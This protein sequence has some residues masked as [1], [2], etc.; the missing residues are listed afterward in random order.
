MTLSLDSGEVAGRLRDA[1]INGVIEE[2]PDGLIIDSSHLIDVAAYL[3]TAPG[4]ELDYLNYITAVDYKDHFELIYLLSSLAHNHGLVI[5][6]MLTERESPSLPSVTG[7]WQ[8]TD[9]QEREIFDLF[10]IRFEGHP[11]MK[12]I[13]MW[14]GFEGYPLRKDFVNGA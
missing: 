7:L 12:R 1:G 10:G 2:K 11:N 13:F 4:I 6:T 9:F 14:E 5:K 8:G 3:K